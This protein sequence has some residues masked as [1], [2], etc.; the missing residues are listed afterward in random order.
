MFVLPIIQIK[1]AKANNFKEKKRCKNPHKNFCQSQH[2]FCLI[3][4]FQ[5]GDSNVIMVV[6]VIV[7]VMVS[8]QLNVSFVLHFILKNQLVQPLV[9]KE[10]HT[11]HAYIT[12]EWVSVNA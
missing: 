10:E 2:V 12:H 5:I 3:L 9:T 6:V 4:S 1:A 7:M 11:I 8:K